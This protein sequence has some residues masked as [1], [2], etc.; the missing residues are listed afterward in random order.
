MLAFDI[1]K[2]YGDPGCRVNSRGA[3]EPTTG[4]AVLWGEAAAAE[5]ARDTA[6]A[7]HLEHKGV[8]TMDDRRTYGRA[9]EVLNDLLDVMGE[10]DELGDLPNL[11]G[12]REPLT[13]ASLGSYLIA[14]LD[15]AEGKRDEA[16]TVL[17]E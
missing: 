15:F 4:A 8:N 1:E 17:S 6:G 14:L 13:W 10:F 11:P 16:R 2:V 7:L 5:G 9:A 12:G 3:T